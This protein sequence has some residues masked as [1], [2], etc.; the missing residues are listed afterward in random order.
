MKNLFTVEVDVS[1]MGMAIKELGLEPNGAVQKFF[2]NELMR[3]SDDYV[4]MNNGPLKNSAIAERDGTGIIYNSPYA[5]YHWYGK[6]A[7]DPVTGKGAFF[8]EGYGFWSR[9]DTKKVITNTDMQYQGA[10]NRG[11]R[12]VERCFVDHKESLIQSTEDFTERYNK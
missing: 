11:P 6:L 1:Q 12:W 5:K 4:P 10:P 3:L 9:K 8:K 2:T 7:V